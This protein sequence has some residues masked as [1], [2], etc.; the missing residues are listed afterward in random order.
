M[1]FDNVSE[2][3]CS[4]IIELSLLAS[5]NLEIV[6]YISFYDIDKC[7][8]LYSW[9]KTCFRSRYFSPC[10]IVLC[11]YLIISML[12]KELDV[13]LVCNAIPTQSSSSTYERLMRCSVKGLPHP[14]INPMSCLSKS[15]CLPRLL[16]CVFHIYT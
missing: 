3:I 14:A 10:I 12:R 5:W 6:S 9:T 1:Y 7:K 11:V 16:K 4:A 8:C 15:F 2:Q 13:C